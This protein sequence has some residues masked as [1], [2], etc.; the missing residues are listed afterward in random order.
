MGM[1]MWL[2]KE[3]YV[4]MKTE[5]RKLL[6][7]ALL[8]CCVGL[9]AT[10]QTI[11]Q[12]FEYANDE[13]LRAVWSPFS[14]PEGVGNPEN[15]SLSS[16]VDPASTG[17][18]SLKLTRNF[19]SAWAEETITG[20][21]LTTPLVISSNQYVSFRIAGDP[22]VTN[23]NYRMVYIYG[24]D[25][26]G[27]VGR[28]AS[29]VPITTNWHVV[30]INLGGVRLPYGASVFPDFNNMTNFSI[31]VIGQ[32]YP[33]AT[34]YDATIYIDDIQI[35]DTPLPSAA[36]PTG[37]T[38]VESFEYPSDAELPWH[39]ADYSGQLTVSDNVAPNQT[40]STKSVKST[41][42][43]GGL[44]ATEVLAGPQLPA[45]LSIKPD[46][47]ITFRIAGDPQF[48]NASYSDIYVYAWDG[49]GY[50]GRWKT[51]VPTTTN[52][53]I[54]NIKASTLGLTWDAKT[55]PDLN[56]ITELRFYIYGQG[57][58][59]KTP[60]EGTI[61]LDDLQI[62][63]TPL[64]EFPPA[65]APR[66]LIE[67][68]ESYADETALLGFYEAVPSGATP[69]PSLQTP[70]PQG[71]KALKLT[72]DYTAIQY[73]WAAMRSATVAPFSFPTN[74]VVQ[75]KFKGDP[76]MAPIA[77]DGTTVWISFYDDAGRS[78]NFNGAT[79]SVGSGD[80]TTV[81]I[82]YNDFWSTAPTDTGNLVQWRF[83]V[84]G[85]TGTAEATPGPLSATFYF[86]D[87]RI[88]VP[89]TL[90]IIREGGALKLKISGLM[91]GESYTIKQTTNFTDWTSTT[92]QATGTS[93]TWTIPAGTSGFFQVS[94]P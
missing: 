18:K 60:F 72:I 62:R 52:W 30:N 11:I 9:S 20:P 8:S 3:T 86:D 51:S 80:W 27:N 81:I 49:N 77:D 76:I 36:S 94:T 65:S 50:F 29:L 31:V 48:V 32:A 42:Y 78:I 43:Y 35:R 34:A 7:S 26:V 25:G 90:G 75:F 71:S 13:A 15:I 47:Y 89:P 1:S 19:A 61:Y 14:M 24:Y 44:W 66:S 59:V 39:S 93:Y 64:I 56:N 58:P 87:V 17:T 88:S 6:I 2:P 21:G 67:N 40:G 91:N 55:P 33:A 92:F 57:D 22:A 82:P 45:S 28:W 63:D 10:A 70:A 79:A 74:G 54:M 16:Y 69:T 38:M 53:Q 5:T 46:Q 83:L 85:W 68:F 41:Y 37:V 23:G 12:D 84:Q 4:A 73:P